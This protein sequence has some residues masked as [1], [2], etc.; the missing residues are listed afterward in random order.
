MVEDDRDVGKWHSAGRSNLI[1]RSFVE[2]FGAIP[3]RDSGA[4]LRVLARPLIAAAITSAAVM[5]PAHAAAAGEVGPSG[6]LCFGVDGEPGDAAIVNLTPVDAQGPGFGQLVSSDITSPPST[7][8]V[9]Y[10]PGT[11]DPNVA[12]TPIGTDGQ[13]CYVNA[14]LTSHHL[15]ADHLGT[16]T[17]TSYTPANPNGSP[18]RTIDTRPPPP[19]PQP[20]VNSFP[21]GQFLVGSQIPAGRYVMDARS[22]C[23]WER[24]S[25][26]G[27]SLEEIVAND[28]RAYDGRA[29]VDLAP[30]DVGFEFDSDCGTLSTYTGSTQLASSIPA[31]THVVNQHIS[32]GTYVSDVAAGC[33]WERTASFA[34]TID[35]VITNDFVSSA[36]QQFVTISA[37]DVGFTSDADCGIWK[38]V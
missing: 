36:G 2:R 33:Y 3:S 26:L 6:R 21:P 23:Y 32:P 11:F 1:R 12:V 9:N 29:I 5:S 19:P 35:A 22:G 20:Q 16:I 4:R 31:G 27:G 34:G 14:D 30:T 17:A 24:Q 13:V 15:V 18:R 28:F 8:N 37:T 38:R 25:G 10:G 7:S